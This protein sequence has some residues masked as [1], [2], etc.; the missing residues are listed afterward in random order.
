MGSDAGIRTRMTCGRTF[1]TSHFLVSDPAVT[2]DTDGPKTRPLHT[3][4][5]LRTP[6]CER[7]V[8]H[9]DCC[10]A[11]AAARGSVQ[12]GMASAGVRQPMRARAAD[13]AALQQEGLPVR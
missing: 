11:A 2:F 4:G 13:A 1:I 3:G 8:F 6:A 7:L 9:E 12:P 10:A 5:A